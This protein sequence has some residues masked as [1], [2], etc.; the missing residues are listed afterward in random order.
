MC[1]L[2]MF[3][4]CPPFGT[5]LAHGVL[6][7]LDSAAVQETWTKHRRLGSSLVD[8]LKGQEKKHTLCATLGIQ[9]VFGSQSF[10][11]Q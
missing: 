4:Y 7:K 3:F 9:A 6:E 11:N 1:T 8:P 2:Y 5:M 10:K